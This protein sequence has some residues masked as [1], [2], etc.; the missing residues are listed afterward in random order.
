MCLRDAAAARRERPDAAVTTYRLVRGHDPARTAAA[1]C[2]FPAAPTSIR[3]ERAP[4]PRRESERAPAA[5]PSRGTR[6]P[7]RCRRAAAATQLLEQQDEEA[8]LRFLQEAQLA[9]HIQH[10]NTVYIS[11]FG[12][13]E[14]GRAYLVMEFLSG[15]TL[16][17]VLEAGP[18]GPLRACQVALQIARGLSVIHDKGIVHR[19]L[20]PAN[21]P[22]E[23]AS[24]GRV[25]R[26]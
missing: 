5:A 18:L 3:P 6:P 11:D 21:V 14:D 23:A 15:P 2:A 22:A 16:A 12:V 8:Q 9:S 17:K 1:G 10:P 4:V 19:D 20:K 7:R 26:R 13:L 25:P 24:R